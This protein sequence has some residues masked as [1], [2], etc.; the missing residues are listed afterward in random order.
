M[1]RVLG[2]AHRRDLVYGLSRAGWFFSQSSAGWSAGERVGPALAELSFE[3]DR[4]QVQD[5]IRAVSM[6]DDSKQNAGP[7]C[8]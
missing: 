7:N 3:Q 6:F 2:L 4:D 5:Q 1:A 8:R